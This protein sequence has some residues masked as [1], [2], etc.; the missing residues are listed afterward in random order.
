MNPVKPP[1]DAWA[2]YELINP[3]DPYH[4]WAPSP[5]VAA[6]CAFMIGNGMVGADPVVDGPSAGG[7]LLFMDEDKAEAEILK[8][9]GLSCPPGEA[10]KI[11]SESHREE[12]VMALQSVLIGGPGAWEIVSVALDA[13]DDEA[14]AALLAEWHDKNRSSMTDLKHNADILIGSF[15]EKGRESK[16]KA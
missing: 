13:L 3:S 7:L 14:G 6:F 4:F 16:A 11:F 5:E 2:Q 12:I 15:Q 1:D 9:L 10:V 8:C